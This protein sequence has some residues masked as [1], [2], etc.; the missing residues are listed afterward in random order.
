MN[1]QSL[2]APIT[3]LMSGWSS[4][5]S[6]NLY[7]AGVWSVFFLL[8]WTRVYLENESGKHLTWSAAAARYQ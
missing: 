4:V 7:L 3:L 2:N 8:N 5:R 1:A 6:L